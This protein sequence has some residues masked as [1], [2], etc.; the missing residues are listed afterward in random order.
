MQEYKTISFNIG[1]LFQRRVFFSGVLLDSMIFLYFLTLSGE[2]LNIPLGIFKPRV[3]HFFAIILMYYTFRASRKVALDRELIFPFFALFLSFFMS[4]LMGDFVF[5]SLGYT[6]IYLFTIIC[7]FIV[8]YNLFVF[9]CGDRVFKLYILS[10]VV[11]GCYSLMQVLF[12]FGGII[13]PFVTQYAGSIARGQ[14]WN[15]EPSYYALI[16]TQFVMFYNSL[17][18]MSTDKK[19][20]WLYFSFMNL[21]LLAS[22]STGIVLSYPSFALL[23]LLTGSL[24]FL[25]DI[26]TNV[27]KKAFQLLM[28]FFSSMALLWLFFP[29]EFIR[30]FYKFFDYGI[31]KHWSIVERWNGIVN[32]WKVFCDHPFFGVG[33]GGVG[34]YIYKLKENGA[35]PMTLKELEKYDPTNAFCEILASTG[36]FGLCAYLLLGRAFW[37]AFKKIMIGENNITLH[38]KRVIVSLFISL[39][40]ALFVLQFNQG[41]FRSYLWVHAAVVFGYMRYVQSLHKKSPLK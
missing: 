26:V 12:S 11:I 24:R 23:Y 39:I 19:I 5:R 20:N 17:A 31:T 10:F 34:S 38:H 7:Y 37:I 40:S 9:V 33:V 25:R 36:L 6:C 41:L 21:L 3:N 35:T 32:S 22:T 30:T 18:L 1:S 16:M 4:A 15:Y 28:F 8:P 29:L 14:G 27:K 13:L 2:L